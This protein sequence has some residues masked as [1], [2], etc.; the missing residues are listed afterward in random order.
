MD[1]PTIGR[2][3]LRRIAEAWPQRAAMATSLSVAESTEDN[4]DPGK[5][6]YPVTAVPF[7]NH[8]RFLDATPEQRQRV[9]TGLWL[10]YN[11]RVIAT[12]RLIAEPAFALIMDGVFP[13]SADPLVAQT[14]QQS[15][16]DESFH[17]Y[18]HMMALSRTSRLR[19]VRERPPLPRL[20]THRRLEQALA[21]T[22]ERWERDLAVLVWGAVAE[23]CISGLLGVLARDATV[24]PMH[25]LISTLHLRDESA[26]GSIVIEVVTRLHAY[27][28]AAQRDAVARFLPPA[29]EAFA[30][31]DPSMLRIEL[32]EAGIDGVEEILHDI[33][34]TPAGKQLVLDMS[35]ARRL[36]RELG[37]ADV[38]D[39]D[40]SRPS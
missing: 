31:Q 14:V 2:S 20:V 30:A 6:D 10:G 19:G 21:T 23:T 26:H 35:G 13:G 28:N 34:D 1:E 25:S 11:E 8:P 3:T 39:F 15:L 33:K 32:T 9:L 7:A 4:Y 36:V 18:M 27:M 5:P 12:E 38:V 22:T 37:L 17:T 24:Q 16:V 40:F 29:L